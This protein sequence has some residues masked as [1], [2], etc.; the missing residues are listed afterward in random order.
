MKMFSL[1]SS[2]LVSLLRYRRVGVGVGV[3]LVGEERR[4]GEGRHP[5]SAGV[6]LCGGGG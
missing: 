5:C 2:S 4:R 1:A 3:W 6:P